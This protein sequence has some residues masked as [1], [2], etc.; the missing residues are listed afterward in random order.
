M[1]SSPSRVPPLTTL[2]AAAAAHGLDNAALQR[3]RRLLRGRE[4]LQRIFGRPYRYTVAD[5]EHVIKVDRSR[6]AS[7]PPSEDLFVC[8]CGRKFISDECRTRHAAREHAS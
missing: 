4:V 5:V 1:S 8:A 7:F 6:H 2:P 3:L